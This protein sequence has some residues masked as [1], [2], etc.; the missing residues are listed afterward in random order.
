MQQ[1]SCSSI[2]SEMDE[3]ALK[4]LLQLIPNR[5]RLNGLKLCLA[6]LKRDVKELNLQLGDRYI[7]N[8]QSLFNIKVITQVSGPD[9]NGISED[10]H[11][12]FLGEVQ[13]GLGGELG[14]DHTV[15]SHL[16]QRVFSSR[17]PPAHWKEM[18]ITIIITHF[19]QNHP[20]IGS[21]ISFVMSS[22]SKFL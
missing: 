18:K 11:P 1:S 12:K 7:L 15:S 19:C 6:D 4:D 9:P 10:G 16:F 5:P 8:Q 20:F 17:E 14:V 3:A 13:Q 22:H 2:K 21:A